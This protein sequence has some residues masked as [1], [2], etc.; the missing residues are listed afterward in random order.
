MS[1]YQILIPEETWQK[2]ERYQQDLHSDTLV[3]GDY[4]QQALQ[5]EDVFKLDIKVF[6]EYLINTKKPKIF[7]EVEIRGDGSDWN[8]TE[9][10]ILGDISIAVPVTVYDDGKHF[11]PEIYKEP[12]EATLVYVPGALL[13][14]GSKYPPVDFQ[15]VTDNN[16]NLIFK[17]YYSLYQRRLRPVFD[18]INKEAKSKGK[19]AFITVPGL[20]CGQFAGL[21]KGQLGEQLKQVF[22]KFLQNYASQFPDIKAVYYDPYSECGNERLEIE[23]ISFFVRPFTKGNNKS[24]LCPPQTYAEKDD[25]NNCH[26]FSLVAWDHVSWPGNDFYIGNRATDDG[27]KAAATSSMSVLT[28]IEGNYNATTYSFD[29]PEEYRNWQDVVFKR[30]LQLSL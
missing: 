2:L 16:K 20:G 30:K 1:N 29:P 6:F 17:R 3:C 12:F 26:L 24:Q 14:S 15:E 22:I 19:K 21:F 11:M 27:V 10:S 28:G 9:L 8:Q 4:L 23:H 25:F 7:A 18:Y 13:R 5:N